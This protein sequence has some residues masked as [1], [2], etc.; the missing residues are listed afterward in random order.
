MTILKL[1][2]KKKK[3]T[4]NGIMIEGE[5]EFLYSHLKYDATLSSRGSLI[6]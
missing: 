4:S 6:G 3:S 2:K 1:L 5:L